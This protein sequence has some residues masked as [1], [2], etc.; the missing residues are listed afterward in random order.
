MQIEIVVPDGFNLLTGNHYFWPD[1]DIKINSLE[2]LLNP[3]DS[4]IILMLDC[5]VPGYNWISQL[6]LLFQNER[7]Y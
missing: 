6:T 7:Q 2:S 1:S 5:N 3:N 4:Q